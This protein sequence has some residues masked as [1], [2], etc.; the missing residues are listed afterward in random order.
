MTNWKF[1]GKLAS[2]SCCPPASGL[3]QYSWDP[4]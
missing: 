1:S 3:I 4:T 2:M